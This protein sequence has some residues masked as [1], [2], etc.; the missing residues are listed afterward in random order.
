MLALAEDFVDLLLELSDAQVDF[1]VPGGSAVAFHGYPRATKD[2]DILLRPSPENAE[3]VYAAL[4]RFGAPLQSFEVKK[5]DFASYDGVLQLGVPPHR[6][7]PVIGLAALLKNKRA[8]GRPQDLADV[9][10]LCEK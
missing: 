2:L 6:I 1:V 7:D 3:L 8:S 10:R 9:A 4:A 5:E